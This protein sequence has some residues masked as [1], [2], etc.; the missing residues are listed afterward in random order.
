MPAG[1]V[2]ILTTA[3]SP[4]VTGKKGDQSLAPDLYL[5]ILQICTCRLLVITKE[6]LEKPGQLL[7]PLYQLPIGE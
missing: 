3:K 1:L 7:A 5:Q 4:A 6:L 2:I